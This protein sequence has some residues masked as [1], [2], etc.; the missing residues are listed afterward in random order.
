MKKARKKKGPDADNISRRQRAFKHGRRAEAYARWVLRANGDRVVARN[1][2]H[3]LGEVDLI[4]MRGRLVIFVE[5]KSRADLDAGPYAVS[6]AQ[7]RRIS[8]GASGFVARHPHYL[9]LVWRFALFVVGGNG[10][11]QHNKNFWRP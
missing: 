11:F 10:R 6:P 7:W 9:G 4:V 5:V 1:F 3:P 2:R 8:A